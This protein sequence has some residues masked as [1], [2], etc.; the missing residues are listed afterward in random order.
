[1]ASVLEIQDPNSISLSDPVLRSA[2]TPQGEMN[3]YDYQKALRK[4]NRW[5]YTQQANEEVASATQ[6]VLKDF[7]FMG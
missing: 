4:D 6:Q 3:L 2:I 5:Q 7:G 1:M